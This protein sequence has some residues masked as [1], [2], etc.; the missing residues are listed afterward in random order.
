MQLNHDPQ[1]R[2]IK[3]RFRQLD[4]IVFKIMILTV[5]FFGAVSP[6]FR[7]DVASKYA[8]AIGCVLLTILAALWMFGSSKD[9]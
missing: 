2:R 5:L 3:E 9:K 4:R 7:R 6:V 1:Y 8:G